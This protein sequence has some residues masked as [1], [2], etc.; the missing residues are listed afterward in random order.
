MALIVKI[1]PKYTLNYQSLVVDCLEDADDTL[2]TKTLD[3]L[4]R[5]TNK[6][7]VEP[8][9]EKLLSY[10]KE[11]PTESSVR[12]ELVIKINSLCEQYSPNKNWY[13]RTMNKLYEMGGDLI[14]SDLSNKFIQSISDYE[15]EIDGEKFRDSTISIY[16]KMVKKNP[17]IPDSMLQVV[18]WIM[19]EYGST[20]PDLEK[21]NKILKHLCNIA[22]RPLE[23]EL[24]RSY[25]LSAITKLHSTMGFPEHETIKQV[26]DDFAVS[27][28]VDVQQRALEYKNLKAHAGKFS[29]D[30]LM[31]TPMNETSV[32]MQGFDFDLKFLD[33]YVHT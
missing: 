23:D 11:A 30:I 26:I 21:R 18:A 13:V 32:L 25:I 9:V 15:K 22:Y 17:N 20:H 7:N 28:H 2:K 8:I 14:T 19:G 12:K 29:Q 33:S 6:Q 5:M 31:N 3:L 4:Y 16:T 24:T 1:D 27:R 10:L